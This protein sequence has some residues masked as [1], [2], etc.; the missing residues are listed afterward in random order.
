MNIVPW[1]SA[2]EWL[3]V[4]ASLKDNEHKTAL[5]IIEGWR[6]R[7]GTQ[8]PT[9]VL[10]T[11]AVLVGLNAIQERGDS[12]DVVFCAA[13]AVTQSGFNFLHR[14]DLVFP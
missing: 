9:G 14:S 6:R 8:T 10:A 11:H 1:S 7:M 2:Q 13:G 12:P 5:D 4:Y 3:H